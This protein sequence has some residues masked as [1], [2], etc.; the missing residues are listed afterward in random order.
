MKISNPTPTDTVYHINPDDIPPEQPQSAY[1][2]ETGEINWDCP[3]IANMVQP[4]CGDTFKAA[5]ECFVRSEAEPKGSECVDFFREMQD[6]FQKHPEI[7][8]KQDDDEEEVIS[9]VVEQDHDK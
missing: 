6:C 5:F 1:N 3:C 4:P 2:E 9:E 7:Y 8:L